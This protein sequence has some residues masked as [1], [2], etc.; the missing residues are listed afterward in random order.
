MKTLGCKVNTYDSDSLETQFR[1]KGYHVVHDPKDADISILNTCSVTENA[2]KEARYLLR[3]FKRENPEALIVATGCYAQTDSQKLL[4]MDDV[5]LVFPNQVKDRVADVADQQLQIKKQGQALTA[6]RIPEDVKPVSNNRQGHFKSSLKMLAADSN[7]TRAFLKIQ[8]GCNGFCSY[9]LI[10][11]AR[12]ASRSVRA[13][14]VK[15]E[16]R[17]LIDQGVKEIVFTGIHIGDYGADFDQAPTLTQLIAELFSWPDMV[18][19]RISSLEPREL[20]EELLKVLAQ[21]PELFCDHFH[22]PLQAGHDRILKHMRRTYTSA[23]YAETVA[24]AREYFPR[25]NF[26][27]DVIPGFPGESD[28][29]FQATVDFIRKTGLNYLHVFPYSKRPNT[30]AAKMPDHLDGSVVKERS[31]TLRSLSEELKE[32]YVRGFFNETVSVLWE[33]DLDRSGRRVGHSLN[34]LDV[35]APA[36]YEAIPGTID[37]V[38]IKGFVENHR[39][40]GL[41]Q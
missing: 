11:Y 4:G 8:D 36:G 23:Q 15:T 35:V 41:P 9:C 14:E 33:K 12:G 37:Q 40:L 21:R 18:R 22:L 34:Y 25:A 7:K 31:R 20:P 24:M 26:G 39:V 2:D 30:A 29:E 38:K 10:P 3:R 13:D 5:D 1:E 16:V 32:S 6:P 27:A 28:E 19:L 17:R